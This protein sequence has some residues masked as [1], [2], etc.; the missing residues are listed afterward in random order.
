MSPKFHEHL[1]EATAEQATN[2]DES[3]GQLV[4]CLVTGTIHK[5]LQNLVVA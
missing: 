2:D 3:T 1:Y 5:Q 4:R